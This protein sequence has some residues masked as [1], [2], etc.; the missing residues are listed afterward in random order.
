MATL[1]VVGNMAVYTREFLIS[2]F[3]SRYISLPTD[4]FEQ[5]EALAE[6]FYDE[7]GRDKFRLYCSLDA[8]AIRVAKASGFCA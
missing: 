3:L 8:E 5:L 2:A 1:F 7:A 4:K 6:K